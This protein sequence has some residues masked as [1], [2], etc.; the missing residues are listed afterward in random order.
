M[1][2]RV[3]LGSCG[4]LE[5]PRPLE[6]AAPPTRQRRVFSFVL[7]KPSDIP[8]EPLSGESRDPRRFQY[9][10]NFANLLACVLVALRESI[11]DRPLVCMK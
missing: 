9:R 4:G 5:T 6:G 11:L 8:F 7:L 10:L 2:V 3:G 1:N